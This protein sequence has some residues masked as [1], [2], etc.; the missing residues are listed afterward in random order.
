[1]VINLILLAYCASGN[2]GVDEGGESRPPKVPFQKSFGAELS[3]VSCGG[4]VVYRVDNGLSFV[5]GNVHATFEVYCRWPLVICQSFL[6]EQGNKEDPIF[7]LSNTRSTRGSDSEE[8][9]IF[10]ARARSSAWMMTGSG[11]IDVF[12]LSRVV[13][14][15]SCLDNAS[16]GAILVLGVT[17]H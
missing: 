12:W 2:E 7:K 1:M 5:Q 14:T 13:S 16:A 8:D 17:C 10:R 9:W 3:R 4:G 11:Q 15:W 6:E